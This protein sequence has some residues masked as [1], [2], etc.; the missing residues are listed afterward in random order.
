MNFQNRITAAFNEENRR[1]KEAGERRLT[2]T[3]LWKEAGLTSASATFWFSGVNGADLHICA[4]IAPLLRVSAQWLYDGTGPKEPIDSFDYSSHAPVPMIDAKA[5][6]G[7]GKVIFSDDVSK[8][9]MFRRDWL[10][11]KGARPEQVLAFTVDGASM[12]DAHIPDESVVLANTNRRDPIDGKIYVLWIGGELF[13]KQLAKGNDGWIAKSR[14]A[15]NA[16]VYPDI[17]IDVDGRIVGQA[18]WCGF[19]L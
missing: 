2:K 19:G 9:L 4:K 18:F 13:V 15:A 11:K 3:D 10:A 1:R 8:L 5:S 7:T 17:E 12:V 14:N 6:A 16:D